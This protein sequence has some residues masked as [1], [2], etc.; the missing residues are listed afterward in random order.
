MLGAIL[1]AKGLVSKEDIGRAM[2]HQ[3]ENGGRLGDCLAA[4]NLV[5]SEQIEEVLN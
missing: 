4:L 5:T 3:R 2:D 1:V